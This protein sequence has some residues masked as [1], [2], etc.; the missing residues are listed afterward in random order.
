MTLQ[1]Q[2]I[3]D[4][5]DHG[6]MRK[7]EREQVQQDFMEGAYKIIVVTSAFG[8][9]IGKQDIRFVIHYTFPD[10]PET[11]YQEAGRAGRD[12]KPART[13]NATKATAT[14]WMR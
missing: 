7:N 12:G 5:R 10:S 1:K 6:K 11:N 4:A 13:S 2:E 9:G 14:D 8:L 3:N